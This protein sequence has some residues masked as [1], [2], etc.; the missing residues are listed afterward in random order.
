MKTTEDFIHDT[1]FQ[2]QDPNTDLPHKKQD[3]N[4]RSELSIHAKCGSKYPHI[5]RTLSL[6]F[7]LL[8]VDESP[9]RRNVT[10]SLV[11]VF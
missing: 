6:F 5:N 1:R 2:E 8:A 9:R 4:S 11:M 7:N 3:I 10:A